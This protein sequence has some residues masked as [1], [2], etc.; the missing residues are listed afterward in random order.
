[1]QDHEL[2]SDDDECLSEMVD[3]EFPAFKSGNGNDEQHDADASKTAATIDIKTQGWDND[4]IV[5]CLDMA[6][7]Y[8]NNQENECH[9]CEFS[10][11]PNMKRNATTGQMSTEHLQTNKKQIENEISHSDG[12]IIDQPNTQRNGTNTEIWGPSELR[13]KPKWAFHP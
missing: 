11:V 10:P 2:S 8:H 5:R 13:T 6:I 7:K 1:M 4:A 9:H 12:H 3:V